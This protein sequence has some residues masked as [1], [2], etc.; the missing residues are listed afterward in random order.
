MDKEPTEMF[1]VYTTASVA[2]MS[3]I[4]KRRALNYA[5]IAKI[6]IKITLQPQYAI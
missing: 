4:N 2:M 3:G 5:K 6:T 1:D